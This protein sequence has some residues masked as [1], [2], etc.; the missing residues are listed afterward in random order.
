[1][2]TLYPLL[3][4]CALLLL[5]APGLLAQPVQV[6][7]SQIEGLAPGSRNGISNLITR[8]D[9]LLFGPEVTVRSPD[10][11]VT[12]IE[13][14]VF[15]PAGAA[16]P[17]VFSLDARGDTVWV[18]IGFIDESAAGEPQT[19]GGFAFST[20][21]GTSWRAFD[22]GDYLDQADEDTVRYGVSAIPALPVIVPQQSPPFDI[23]LAPNGD[24]WVA[25]WASGLRRLENTA[26]G[27]AR[28]FEPVVLPPDTTRFLNPCVPY[29]FFYAPIQGEQQNG[30]VA[31]SVLVD[32]AGDVWAGTAAGVSRSSDADVLTCTDG[33]S[34]RAWTR[35]PFDGSARALTGDF[36][37][38]VEEQPIGDAAF[39]IGS[40]ENPRNP[41]W[42]VGWPVEGNAMRNGLTRAT[43]NEDGT[44]AFEPK[45]TLGTGLDTRIFDVAFSGDPMQG[46]G[47]IYAAVR[48]GLHISEDGGDSWR[49]VRGFPSAA[50]P[51]RTIPLGPEVAIFAVATTSDAV[52][53]GTGEGLLR[54]TDGG[55]TWTAF[56]ANPAVDTD[57]D[58]DAVEAYAYPNPFS[59]LADGV[60]RIRYDL[61]GPAE[62]TIRV[63]DFGM[64]LVRELT[65]ST[66][67]GPTETLWDGTADNGTRL[68]N[69]VYFYV[70]EA[71]S[72]TFDGKILVL[73]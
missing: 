45:L 24:V 10:G 69:G 61:S 41:V 36:V 37:I 9:S 63:F 60:I 67:G 73:E 71:G 26:D 40:P 35:Y 49:V 7:G 28:R 3:L 27:Y 30:F 59:P 29:N 64:N 44:V 72:Q 13:D 19:L 15:L 32:E 21:G 52:W 65:D 57:A 34:G 42:V 8:G 12:L 54:S 70:I 4:T 33:S 46:T 58:G 23:A 25:G 62:V 66:A 18:G 56:R 53:V 22:R 68:A 51:S 6:L 11:T 38:S 31:F 20:D 16:D 43:V 5:S 39:P 55:A 2:R 48:N 50:D 1:M 17:I 14:T 47:V